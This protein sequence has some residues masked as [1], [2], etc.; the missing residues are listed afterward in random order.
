MYASR[1]GG[2]YNFL[3]DDAVG[4]AVP[5]DDFF[6]EDLFK[7]SSTWGLKVYLQDWMDVETDHLAI[8]EQDVT[9]EENWL[10]QM[11]HGAARNGINILYCMTYS[12]HMMQSVEIENVVSIRVSDDY[13]A[14]NKQWDIGLTD[15]WTFALG[16]APFKDTFWTTPDQPGYADK[17]KPKNGTEWHC[18]LEAA[19]ATLS[20]GIVGISDKGKRLQLPKSI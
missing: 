11:G 6:F 15:I 12:R 5:Q 2:K 16:L 8:F 10:M 14:G 20:T 4:A 17:G 1:N 19:I 3:I 18:E 13:Y 9:I 7:N